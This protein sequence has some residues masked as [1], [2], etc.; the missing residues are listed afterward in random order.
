M[1]VLALPFLMLVAGSPPVSLDA[2]DA[3]PAALP[4]VTVAEQPPAVMPSPAPVETAPA[5]TEKPAARPS[6]PPAQ[7]IDQSAIVV[8]GRQRMPGD[9][10]ERLN[11]QSYDMTRDVDEAVFRPVSVAYR[12]ALPRPIRRGLHNILSNLREP[13]VFVNYLLQLKPG[14][15][16]ETVGR[17]TLNSAIG[18]AGLFDVAKA[19]PFNLP[20][21]PNGLANTL[22]YYGVKQGAFI[23]LPFVGPTTIRDFI[24][25]NI[26]RLVLP[27][28]IG[29]PFNNL[30][31]G[32]PGTAVQVL[33][34]RVEF[35]ERIQRLRETDDP[36]A[37]S[38]D[39]YLERRQAEI[40]A[41]HGR[42][43]PL[44]LPENAPARTT[45]PADQ[46]AEPRAPETPPEEAPPLAAMPAPE[47][48][49][50][51]IVD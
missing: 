34:R 5:A 17:F 38:R 44:V 25:D 16:A 19:K 24:G 31:Y 42:A 43:H 49:A 18:V 22:G 21:R 35:D 15:A 13:V 14:K 30:I 46:P 1:T 10:L 37:A 3:V 4:Q 47:D 32:V 33:D 20:F 50:P 12:R 2:P 23:Y 36:Y 51:A 8:T 11:A 9:P 7:G 28:A 39:F 29:F 41:L 45:K 40:D 48:Q 6:T 26:D 27:L